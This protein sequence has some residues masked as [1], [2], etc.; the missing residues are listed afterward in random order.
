MCFIT[1]FIPYNTS[2]SCHQIESW[3][4]I[5]TCIIDIVKVFHVQVTMSM[6]VFQSSVIIF[7]KMVIN[8]TLKFTAMNQNIPHCANKLHAEYFGQFKIT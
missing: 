7:Y 2:V 3:V 5:F 4:R 1:E 6:A 8:V